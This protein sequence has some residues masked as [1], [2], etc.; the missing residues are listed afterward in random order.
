MSVIS[1]LPI[2][3]E[4]QALVMQFTYYTKIEHQQRNIHKRLMRQFHVC[5]RIDWGLQNIFYD[6]FY[7]KIE[8]FKYYCEEKHHFFLVEI[9]F[10]S[11]IFC[12]KCHQYVSSHSDVPEN[13]IC[14]CI[15]DLVEG[16]LAV[17]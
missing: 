10:M 1:Q 13:L 17:D 16:P 4:L 12:K 9:T 6:Y 5:E 15:P 8:N 2:P 3:K 11:A 14:D 7:Y